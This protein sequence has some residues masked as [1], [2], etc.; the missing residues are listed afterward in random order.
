MGR[1][2]FTSQGRED[3]IVRS[4]DN[5]QYHTQDHLLSPGE[6]LFGLHTEGN[7]STRAWLLMGVGCDVL[8]GPEEPHAHVIVEIIDS[9]FNTVFE[10]KISART[11][12]RDYNP[13]IPIPDGGEVQMDALNP[14]DAGGDVRINKSYQILK[15]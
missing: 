12:S 13:G 10:D 5:L 15:R 6:S 11:G 1:P 3:A 8:E 14:D 2:Q 9:D 4:V 7:D